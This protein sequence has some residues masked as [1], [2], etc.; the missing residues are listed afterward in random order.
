MVRNGIHHYVDF[1]TGFDVRQ[2]AFAIVGLH[3]FLVLIDDADKG[4]SGVDQFA[5]VDVACADHARVGG[6]DVAV[7]QIE[8]SQLD[9]GLRQFHR[10][11]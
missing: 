3:P 4:L 11:L 1:R 9:G 5:D 2:L 10:R 8:L 6:D 7:R